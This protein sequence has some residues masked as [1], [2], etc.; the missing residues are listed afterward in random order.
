[1][2]ATTSKSLT[3][4]G[5]AVRIA[6]LSLRQLAELKPQI[7]L[8]MSARGQDYTSEASREAVMATVIEAAKSAGEEGI[9]RDFL[10]DTIN[11]AN[12]STV[13][14][15]IFERNGFLAKEGEEPG[16]ATAAPSSK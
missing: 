5:R 13:G 7:D 10:L 15:A 3:L 4:G 11:L 8:M 16:E 2:T 6:P 12:F 1:M 9:D 14:L